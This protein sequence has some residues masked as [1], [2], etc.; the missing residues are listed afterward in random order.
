[1]TIPRKYKDAVTS[2]TD[3]HVQYGTSGDYPCV[4]YRVCPRYVPGVFH[5]GKAGNGKNVRACL[6]TGKDCNCA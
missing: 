5:L 3:C 2:C 4:I 6:L 1:M